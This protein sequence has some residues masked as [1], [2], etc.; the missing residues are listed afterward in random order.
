MVTNSM[1]TIQQRHC[2]H[3]DCTLLVFNVSWGE[4]L[5]SYSLIVGAA[6]DVGVGD[7]VGSNVGVG[8]HWY[9]RQLGIGATLVWVDVGAADVGDGDDVGVGV[10]VAMDIGANIDIGNVRWG[11][12]MRAVRDIIGVGGC[13]HCQDVGAAMGVDVGDDGVAERWCCYGRR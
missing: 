13:W 8:R 1:S 2:I 3:S 6:V 7:D 5:E 11:G 9:R 12:T 10:S 4:Q